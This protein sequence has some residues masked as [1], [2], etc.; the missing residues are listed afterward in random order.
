MTSLT[1]AL[2]LRVF[3]EMNARTHWSVRH[4]RL[5]AHRA[6]VRMRLAAERAWP[7]SFPVEVTLTRIAPSELDGDN[8]QSGCKGL[9]DGIA[10]ALGVDDRHPGIAWR[11]AQRRG[12][13]RQYGVEIVVRET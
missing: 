11:Y 12:A 2:P 13:P 4:R 5:S 1:I 8:L 3:S 9:R 10:D 6:L 7:P